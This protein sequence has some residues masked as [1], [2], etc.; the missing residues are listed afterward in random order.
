MT[1]TLRDSRF[2]KACRGEPVDRPP[3]WLMRQAG[4]YMP[5][6]Q[7]VRAAAGSFM[8]LCRTPDQCVEVTL[9]PIRRFGFDASIVFSDILIPAEAM[10]AEVE[11]VAGEGPHINN[12]IRSEA[13]LAQLRSPEPEE[14]APYV[15]ETIKGLRRELPADV[16]LIG[17]VAAP[18]TLLAYLVEGGGSKN[19]EHAKAMVL[20]EPTLARKLIDIIIDYSVKHAAAELEAG[21]Q[22]LQLFD[23]WAELLN[24]DDY[25]RWC[26]EPANEVFRRVRERVGD[27]YP[28]IYFTKGT[29]GHLHH[30]GKSEAGVISIDWRCDL[31]RARAGLPGKVLQ[32]N[33]D[34]LYLYATPDAVRAEATR[35]L[36]AGGGKSHVFNLGH[37]ILPKTPHECVDALVETVRD[38]KP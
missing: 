10:G 35:I 38:W 6:Y 23:T 26:L 5:E 16:P 37:G 32:G 2:L 13:D 7:E 4:R 25:V 11:F 19:F 36:N 31:E 22:V 33:M 34:P 9:Q 12:P 30:L 18:F 28:F 17:F 1:P 8:N 20:G 3:L 15:F 21:A 14:V 27:D 24:P 29:A